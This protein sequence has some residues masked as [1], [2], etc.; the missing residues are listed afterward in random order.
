MPMTLHV[1]ADHRAFEHVKRGERRRAV[2]FVIVGHG[3]AA[4]LLGRKAGLGAVQRLNLALFVDR[5]HDGV[6][7]RIDI[8]PPT[9]IWIFPCASRTLGM[10]PAKNRNPKGTFPS[11]LIPK[12]AM[13]F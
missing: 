10:P 1:A 11:D 5:K 12:S 6:P 4:P 13:G 9:Q 8:R 2:P 7:G 3:A